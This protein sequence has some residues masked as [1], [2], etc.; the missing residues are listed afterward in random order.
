MVLVGESGVGKSSA[1]TQ[2]CE[3]DFRP[4]TS[5]TIGVDFR[6]KIVDTETNNKA[7]KL[8]LWD[9]AGQERFRS[10]TTSYYRMA[11]GIILVYDTSDEATLDALEVARANQ[12]DD[13]LSGSTSGWW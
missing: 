8:Q 9:T 3:D 7:V 5:S 12:C 2:Y 11:D 10:L 4:M 13:A 1:I 6:V